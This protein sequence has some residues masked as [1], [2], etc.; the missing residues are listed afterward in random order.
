MQRTALRLSTIA[1]LTNGGA[2]PWPTLAK[3]AVFDSR[4]DDISDLIADELYPAIV[5]RTD[6][7]TVSYRLPSGMPGRMPMQRYVDLKIEASVMTARR[8]EDGE[9]RPDWADTDAGVEAAVDE[10]S[11]QIEA[12]LLGYGLWAKWWQGLWAVANLSS[13]SVYTSPE[14]G[15]VKQAFRELTLAIHVHNEC[16]PKPVKQDDVDHDTNDEPIVPVHLPE[17]LLSVFDK[18]AA[19]GAGDLKT[20][21]AQI[22]AQLEAQRLPRADAYPMFRTMPT[23]F[24][25]PSVPPTG[26]EPVPQFETDLKADL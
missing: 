21:A 2:L 10:L 20:A 6:D 23:V 8:G 5:V 24:P 19:D 14:R 9:L 25:N 13:V 18:I 17:V 16:Y 3:D 1:A 22:R 4:Q 11:Y 15:R 7:D 12:A 26:Q